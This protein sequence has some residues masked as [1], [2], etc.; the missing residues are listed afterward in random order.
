MIYQI[1]KEEPVAMD[2]QEVSI[3]SK[4]YEYILYEETKMI[5]IPT[6]DSIHAGMKRLYYFKHV[7]GNDYRLLTVNKYSWKKMKEKNEI[8]I[9][10]IQEKE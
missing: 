3:Y 7:F 5:M 4:E 1:Q 9:L 8:K 10:K 2:R 6:P